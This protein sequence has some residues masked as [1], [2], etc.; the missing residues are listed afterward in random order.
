[1]DTRIEN[2]LLVR[3]SPALLAG[4][5]SAI[6]LLLTAIG[7]YGV[8]SFAVSQRRREIGVRMALGAQPG[9]IQRQFLSLA[10]KLLLSGA[11]IG[12]IG[13]GLMGRAMQVL[14]FNV[15]YLD[16]PTLSACAFVV[17]IV[18]FAACLW[19]ARRAARISP[20]VALADQ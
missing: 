2:S 5:F 1:M 7:I 13:A 4:L 12:I 20:V 18:S 10:L 3:R 8:L 6:A 11:V 14:L 16:L 17:T 19:P 15:S 9:Q